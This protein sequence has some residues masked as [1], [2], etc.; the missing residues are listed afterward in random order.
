MVVGTR[1]QGQSEKVPPRG[2]H[3][4][5]MN[6]G[7]LLTRHARYCPHH[8]AVAFG[9]QRPT[10]GAFDAGVDRVANP[11]RNSDAVMVFAAR[12][13]A[14]PLDAI[15]GEVPAIAE[16]RYVLTDG[17]HPGLRTYAG[18]VSGAGAG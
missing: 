14:D 3:E 10:F 18:L 7:T 4:S 17:D 8:P 16:G 9:N 13:S 2:P 11:L 12:A 1:G 5:R 15:R 6:I